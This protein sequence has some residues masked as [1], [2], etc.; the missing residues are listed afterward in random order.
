MEVPKL[1]VEQELPTEEE[2]E[3][4]TYTGG[5]SRSVRPK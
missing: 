2:F 5:E 4:V 3:Q 1:S